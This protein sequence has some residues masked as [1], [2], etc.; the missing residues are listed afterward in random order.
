MQNLQ[1]KNKNFIKKQVLFVYFWLRWVSV[2]TQAFLRLGCMG[3]SLQW[4]LRE[5]GL[6]GAQASGVAKR[7]LSSCAQAQ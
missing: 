5:R 7:G 4:L 2:A 1:E 6:E 3:Y